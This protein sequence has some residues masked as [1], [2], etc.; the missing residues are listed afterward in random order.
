MPCILI[1][2]QSSDM[3]E[4]KW[5]L[6]ISGKNIFLVKKQHAG[7][8]NLIF[9]FGWT[10]PLELRFRIRFKTEIWHMDSRRWCKPWLLSTGNLTYHYTQNKLYFYCQSHYGNEWRWQWRFAHTHICSLNIQVNMIRTLISVSFLICLSGIKYMTIH[11][12]HILCEVMLFTT[13]QYN[14]YY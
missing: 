11:I 5:D 6:N 9:F 7:V 14:Y 2:T 10:V 4:C 3:L 8:R 1:F 13:M 12:L